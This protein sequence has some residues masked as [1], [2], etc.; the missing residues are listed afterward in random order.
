MLSRHHICPR[1]SQPMPSSE[2]N[3][4]ILGGTGGAILWCCN[5]RRATVATATRWPNSSRHC[6]FYALV[7]HVPAPPTHP[8]HLGLCGTVCQRSQ[9]CHGPSECAQGRLR[10]QKCRKVVRGCA[11]SNPAPKGGH[12]P[13]ETPLCPTVLAASAAERVATFFGN[14]Y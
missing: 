4:A 3:R 6:P 12:P 11:L 8:M 9:G 5:A 2:P 10:P 1:I 7:Q 13:L 14:Y